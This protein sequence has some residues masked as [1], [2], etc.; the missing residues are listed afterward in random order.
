MSGSGLMSVGGL[1]MQS[2]CSGK[3]CFFSLFG[4]S[5]FVLDLVSS[6]TLWNLGAKKTN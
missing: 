1:H 4:R 2:V 5:T 3:S 6:S